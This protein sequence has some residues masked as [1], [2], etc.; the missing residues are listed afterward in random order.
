MEAAVRLAGLSAED[1]AA[2]WSESGRTGG[3]QHRAAVSAVC[4][5]GYRGRPTLVQWASA[6]C[7][8]FRCS[9][10]GLGEE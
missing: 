10:A 1:W 2:A 5:S 7:E 6:R 3:T 4:S 8:S 9:A